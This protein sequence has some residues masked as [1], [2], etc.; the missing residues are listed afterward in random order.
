MKKWSNGTVQEKSYKQME[1]KKENERIV[2]ERTYIIQE[3]KREDAY[4]KLEERELF[5]HKPV[6]PFM[7][8]NTYLK[9]LDV[10]QTFL[11]PQNSN[12]NNNNI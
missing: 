12:Y 10:Q 8:N 5:T 7:I 1:K 3:S 11:I 2:C 9:D 4:K 6:N